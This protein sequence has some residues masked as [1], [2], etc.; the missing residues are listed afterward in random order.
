MNTSCIDLFSSSYTFFASTGRWFVTMNFCIHAIMYG[1]F[2]LRAIR[3]RVPRSIQ[4]L[5]TIL[6]LTQML[7]GC[8]INLSALDYKRQ[9]FICGTTTENIIV[10]LILYAS[11]LVLFAHFFYQTY[12][13][14]AK[15]RQD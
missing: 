9:G 1:Y 15:V 12:V 6:Q 2:A 4:Q 8:V 7:V 5:I 11:Y 3:V 14:K 13:R 10:S